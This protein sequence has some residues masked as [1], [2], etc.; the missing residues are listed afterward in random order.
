[1]EL[2]L[3]TP[4]KSEYRDYWSSNSAHMEKQGCYAWMAE[5]LRPLRPSRVLDIGCGTGE[6]LLALLSAFGP[7]IVS[8]EEN[9]ACIQHASDAIATAGYAVEPVYRLAYVEHSDGTH[10]IARDDEPIAVSK[11][12]AIVHADP[13]LNDPPLTRFL[14]AAPLFDAVTVW[15][16]GTYMMRRSCRSLASLGI[17]DGSDYRLRV[18]NQVYEIADRV[19]RPGGWLHVVDRGEPPCTP[20]LRN[21]LLDSH[22]AQAEPTSLEVFALDYR[23][24]TEPKGRGVRLVASPGTSGE[25]RDSD[26]LTTVSVLSRK[27]ER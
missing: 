18:Q 24:Y 5:Q 25:K 13:L 7:E 2:P 15:L 1:M 27:P 20:A 26:T 21:D 16:I 6:G 12:V 14:E 10:E 3:W 11:R 17:A 19:L 22:R 8:L 4:E 9:G 23:E